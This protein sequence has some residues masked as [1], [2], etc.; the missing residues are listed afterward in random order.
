MGTEGKREREGGKERKRERERERWGERGRDREGGHCHQPF[1]VVQLVLLPVGRLLY[2]AGET[3]WVSQVN[4]GRMPT[5][6]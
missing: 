3:W 6:L 1:R 2:P 4:Q 5:N